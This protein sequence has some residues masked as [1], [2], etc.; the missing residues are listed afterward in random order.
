MSEAEE[1]ADTIDGRIAE[2]SEGLRFFAEAEPD[3]ARRLTS[4]G[5]E[6]AVAPDAGELDLRRY[7]NKAVRV[8]YRTIGPDWV[9]G[10]TRIKS[11]RD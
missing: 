7:R 10:V 8:S 2:T 6:Q 4:I 11:G 5:P 1:A 9:Y 3:R